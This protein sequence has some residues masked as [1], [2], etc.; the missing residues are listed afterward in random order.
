MVLEVIIETED[1]S[2]PKKRD[3]Q[4][5]ADSY[6]LTI[7]VLADAN[8]TQLWSYAADMGGSVGLPFTVILDKG[9][10]IDSIASGSQGSAVIRKF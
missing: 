9:V 4:R 7:P 6:G 2:V 10:V 3:L 5:W 1:G 8:G